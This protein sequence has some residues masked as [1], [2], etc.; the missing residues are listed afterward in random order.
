MTDS[1]EE[2]LFGERDDI[3][4]EKS[5]KGWVKYYRVRCKGKGVDRDLGTGKFI[6]KILYQNEKTGELF[7]LEEVMGD[8][9]TF[10]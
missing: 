8:K 7:T 1:D 3:V 10:H 2:Y 4:P 6:S 9:D 5:E